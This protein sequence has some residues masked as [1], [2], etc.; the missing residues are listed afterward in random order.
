MVRPGGLVGSLEFGVP[1]PVARPLWELYVRGGLPLA[2]RVLRNGWEEVGGFLGGSIRE[3]WARYPLETQLGLW[4]AAGLRDIGV[5][6][7]SLG[8]GVVIWGTR[9]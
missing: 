5:R 3:F 4:C 6:R 1:G 9:A 2:G 8:A 7:L